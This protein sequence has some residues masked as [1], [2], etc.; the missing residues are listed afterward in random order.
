[1]NM[2]KAII[3]Q[4]ILWIIILKF[5][6]PKNNKK[7]EKPLMLFK[8]KKN[9]Q[10]IKKINILMKLWMIQWSYKNLIQWAYKCNKWVKFL[11]V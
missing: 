1:M 10:I 9:N 8:S 2:Q 3:Q 5:L 11:K 7:N 4:L 6:T